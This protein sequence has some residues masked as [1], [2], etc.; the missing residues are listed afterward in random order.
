M[1]SLFARS[2]RFAALCALLASQ[3][4]CGRSADSMPISA[5]A[6]PAAAATDPAPAATDP[7]PAAKDP[8]PAAAAP[9]AASPTAAEPAAPPQQ[10]ADS[11]RTQK[12]IE[13]ISAY[14]TVRAALAADNL[15]EAKAKAPALASAAKAAVP[16]WAGTTTGDQLAPLA[17]AAEAVATAADIR[18][19]RFAFG[20]ASKALI[21]AIAPEPSLQVGLVAYRC[22]MAKT[23]QK[24]LQ[25]GDAMGNP[26]WGA[27]MLTCGAKV[28][29]K[30]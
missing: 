2:A 28:P 10:L 13:V 7:A 21:T 8:A 14:A 3:L 6:S 30:P 16:V 18:A 22:P 25:T 24:W 26:Y 27:E 20:D 11:P 4:G 5:D 9:A 23:Y 12:V 15:S 1:K 19:A 29:I 17:T